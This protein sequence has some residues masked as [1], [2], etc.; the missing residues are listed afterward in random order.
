M[1]EYLRE[2]QFVTHNFDFAWK[3]HSYGVQPDVDHPSASKA[4]TI[5]G[6]DIYHPSQDDL[7]GKEISFCGDM[8]RSLKRIIILSLRQKH[9]AFRVDTLSRST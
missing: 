8:T 5:A 9:K 1:Q 4:L 6:C 7:T 2:D 3:G